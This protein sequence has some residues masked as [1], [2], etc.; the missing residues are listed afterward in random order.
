[1]R[2]FHQ[3]VLE[4]QIAMRKYQLDMTFKIIHTGFPTETLYEKL[5][6][7]QSFLENVYIQRPRKQ[8]LIAMKLLA[9]MR[10]LLLESKKCMVQIKTCVI[11]LLMKV[12]YPRN[13]KIID[14]NISFAGIS[15]LLKLLKTVLNL[16]SKQF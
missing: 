7:V 16:V 6:A 4:N 5:S 11:S 13:S 12:C 10:V 1:M 2:Y 3:A 14:S 15:K 8:H 9:Q